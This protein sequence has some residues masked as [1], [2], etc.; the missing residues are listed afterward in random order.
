MRAAAGYDRSGWQSY[1]DLTR[2][3]PPHI[4][5]QALAN[6]VSFCGPDRLMFGTDSRVPG[7]LAKQTE[8]IEI[9]LA[10]F[11]KLGVD[12]AATE[13]IMSGTADEVFP[14]GR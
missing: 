11:E 9:D 12:E 6:A 14:A 10:I 2:G 5:E 13:R 4:R 7:G 8:H 1:V 3:T